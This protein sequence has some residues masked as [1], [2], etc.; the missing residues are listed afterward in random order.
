VATLDPPGATPAT[1]HHI[2]IPQAASN[3]A[4]VGL[5]PPVTMTLSGP[6]GAIEVPLEG[7]FVLTLSTPLTELTPSNVFVTESGATAPLAGS[8]ACKN[9]SNHA[10]D[11]FTGPVKTVAITPDALLIPGT[12]FSATLDPAGAAPALEGGYPTPAAAAGP[13]HALTDLDQ[14]SPAVG[15]TWG[16]VAKDQAFGGKYVAEEQRFGSATFSFTGHR[17]QLIT[18]DGPDRGSASVRIDGVLVDE[19]DGSAPT[20][21]YGV[22]HDYGHLVE[23]PHTISITTQSSKGDTASVGR[24][25]AVDAFRVYSAAGITLFNNPQMVYQWGRKPSGK[26]TFGAYAMTRRAGAS[27][28]ITFRGTAITWVTLVGPKQGGARVLID[29]TLVGTFDNHAST[30]APKRRLFG[31]LANGLHTLRI[32]PGG[33]GLVVVD[34]FL[35]KGS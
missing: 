10:V 26:A 28:S 14:S 23:G 7:P 19:I 15:Y 5:G 29:G 22:V 31:G 6:K 24:L 32:V 21:K 20:V 25:V 8:M 16:A 30:A 4:Q 3:P 34:G 27:A 13:I 18:V 1:Y 17:V 33:G 2:D 35:V 12:L 9:A 11:C